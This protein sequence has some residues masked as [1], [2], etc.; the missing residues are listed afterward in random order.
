M[1]ANQRCDTGLE[2]IEMLIR[3]KVILARGISVW[4]KER[5]D[6]VQPLTNLAA[7]RAV[8]VCGGLVRRGVHES[9]YPADPVKQK[10][11]EEHSL[12]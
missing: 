4:K 10:P 7:G 8:S 1:V 5:L 9:A 3:S 12:V 6:Q 2:A 11:T